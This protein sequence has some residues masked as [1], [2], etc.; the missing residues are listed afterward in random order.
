MFPA[1]LGGN[2]EKILPSE[3]AKAYKMRL[4]AI[5]KKRKVGRPGKNNLTPVVSNL[6]TIRTD[7]KLGKEVGESQDQIRRYIRLTELISAQLA[8]PLPGRS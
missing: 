1:Q 3:K 4:E 6:D 7:E 5:T 2:R 8:A